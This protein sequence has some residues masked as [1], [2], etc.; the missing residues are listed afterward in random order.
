LRELKPRERMKLV[1]RNSKQKRVRGGKTHHRDKQKQQH[2]K[3][4]RVWDGEEG[5]ERNSREGAGMEIHLPTFQLLCM[6][7]LLDVYHFI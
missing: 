6:L 7:I 1:R 2:V 5:G 3:K 4:L